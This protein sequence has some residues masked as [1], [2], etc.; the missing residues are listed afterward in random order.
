MFHKILA[1]AGVV[2]LLTGC[3]NFRT[4]PDRL[5]LNF[6]GTGSGVERM[7]P[8]TTGMGQTDEDGMMAADCFEAPFFSLG[9][10]K[11]GIAQD[12][13]TVVSSDGGTPTGLGL[14]IIGTTVFDFDRGQGRLVVQGLTTV[15][16]VNWPTTDGEVEFTHV[17]GA[18]G[19]GAVV[20][21]P[22]G[23]FA[24]TGD[25]EGR[26]AVTR[27]SGLVDMARLDE[28]VITFDCLFVVDV[29]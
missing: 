28:G 4:D 11:L 29:K 18:A 15:Q 8:D 2:G 5:V 16:P 6:K 27:L 7:V 24:N 21:A 12:C 13:L 22:A 17:T 1:I 9:G 10:K 14:Q 19:A 25:F 20:V 26:A 23:E 3:G